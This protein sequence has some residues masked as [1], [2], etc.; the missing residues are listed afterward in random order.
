MWEPRRFTALRASTACYRDSFTFLPYRSDDGPLVTKPCIVT[1]YIRVNKASCNSKPW[2]FV[3]MHKQETST[4]T[5]V[6]VLY[7]DRRSAGQSVLE[8][9]THLGLTTRSW[10][11]SDSCG[12]V[13]LGRPFWRE[14]GSGICNCYWPSPAQSFSGPSPLRLVAIFYCLRFETSLFVASY[15]SQG[16]GGGIRTRLH[17]GVK[18][19]SRGS[20]IVV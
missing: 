18:L 10:L 3:N 7:Y 2:L 8:Q 9:S 13:H 4:E 14:D 17:A 1:N 5:R 6:W 11:L 15:D 19:E 16:H 20:Q 12:C